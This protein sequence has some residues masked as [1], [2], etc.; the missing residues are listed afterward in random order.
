MHDSYRSYKSAGVSF[1]S[2]L[3]RYGY[4]LSAAVLDAEE[5]VTTLIMATSTSSLL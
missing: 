5:N 1:Q 4:R 3:R 2:A